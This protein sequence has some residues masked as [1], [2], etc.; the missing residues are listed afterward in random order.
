ME[1]TSILPVVFHCKSTDRTNKRISAATSNNQGIHIRIGVV[2]GK[3]CSCTFLGRC[4]CIYRLCHSCL[5][6]WICL[7]PLFYC[8]L[9]TS[10]SLLECSI[11][12][13]PCFKTDVS[14]TILKKQIYKCISVCNLVLMNC[15]KIILG[16]AC[17]LV[18]FRAVLFR[19]NTEE[20]CQINL[21]CI[22]G[23]NCGCHT[24]NLRSYRLRY[25]R[26]LLH[27]AVQQK[28]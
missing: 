22:A 3:G 19:D 9:V 6:V 27:K 2:K 23:L 18:N 25:H 26:I 13:C 14:V 16:I 10:P 7:I 24:L 1:T 4:V 12:N 28:Q 21:V 5:I 15:T 11:T 17:G 8:L 20:L